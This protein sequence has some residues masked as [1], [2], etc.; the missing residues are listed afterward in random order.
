MIGR[1]WFVAVGFL[2]GSVYA[3][4]VPSPAL[5]VGDSWTYLTT[6]ESGQQGWT[7]KGEIITIERISSDSMLV[8]VQQEGSSQAPVE[9]LVGLDWSRVRDIGGKQQVVN[10]PMNFPM[11]PGKKWHLEFTVPNVSA[12]HSSETLR[13]DYVVTGWEDIQL[14][15]GSFKALKIEC[16]GTWTAVLAPSVSTDTHAQLSANG[17]TNVMQ[18]NVTHTGTV[19][20]RSYK[21]YWYV[22]ELKRFVKSV[23][24]SYDTKGVRVKRTTM[25]LQSSKLAG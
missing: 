3:Q 2:C 4:S 7:R 25:E 22:P 10:Q 23:E 11:T 19:G 21:A 24:E 9:Q 6:L 15:M 16:D 14:P 13:D 18:S 1:W 8:A 12:Q 17:A 20:G 5:K